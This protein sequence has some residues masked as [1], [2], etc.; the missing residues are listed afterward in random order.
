MLPYVNVNRGFS[1]EYFKE[2]LELIN[3]PDLEVVGV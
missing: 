1:L 3:K 2:M